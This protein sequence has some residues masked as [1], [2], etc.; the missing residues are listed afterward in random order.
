MA[1]M[2][3]DQI[4]PESFETP[5]KG[6]EI[7]AVGLTEFLNLLRDKK[8]VDYT[9]VLALATDRVTNTPDGIGL[10]VRV[11]LPEDMDLGAAG[12]IAE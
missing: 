12:E 8:L 1:G 3:A 11:L 10:N 9:E 5:Q 7:V 2:S 6:R 4:S